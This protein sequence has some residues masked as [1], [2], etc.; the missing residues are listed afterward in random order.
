MTFRENAMAVLHYEAYEKFPVV[1]F[2]YWGET[3]QKWA[4]EGHIT[5]EE[6]DDYCRRGDNG[7]GDRSIMKKLGFDFN[8]NSC[9]GSSSDLFPAFEEKTLEERPDGSRVIRDGSGLI[10][11]VKPGIVSI[12]AE[13]GTSLTDRS[14][15]E[16]EYLPRL[17]FSME[18]IPTELLE[19]LRDDAGREIPVGIHC[20]SLMGRMRDLLGVEQ[21]SYLMADDFDL[22]EEIID[23]MDGL[24]YECVKA[25]LDSGAKFDYAHFWEDICFKNGPLVIPSMFDE[26]VGPHYKR[27]TD[28]LHS[29]GID[30][31]SVDCDGWIDR[32]IPTWLENGVNTMFPIEV[33]T[34]NANIAPWRE[35][36]GR[37]LRGVG[38]MNKTVFSRDRA[39]VDAEIERLRPLIE[40]GGYI[41]CPDHRIAPDA[42]YENV[43]YYCDRMQNLKL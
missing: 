36:Y 38:G 6:A 22:Y 18:R 4:N 35:Q 28:L 42:K 41:P 5:R 29:H 21:M 11:L 15:W 31:V 16:Q 17:R 10:V 13:I 23:T 34:W 27:I 24:C 33:G 20:G 8:W 14:V 9:V 12:P 2:G 3:V 26:Y 40:L 7:W 32:L 1:S 25:M 43:Q 19:T 39:A 30:I 37:E